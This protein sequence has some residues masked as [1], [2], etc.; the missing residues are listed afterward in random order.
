MNP[1]QKNGLYIHVPFCRTKCPYCG[2]YSI[3]STSLIPRWLE[4]LRKEVAYYK[5]RFE[6]FDTL[7]LGGGTPTLLSTRDLEK[8]MQHLLTHF[9]FAPNTEFTIEANP[10]DLTPEKVDGLKVMG[11]NRV[12]LGVQSFNAEELLFLGRRHTGAEAESALKTLR[13]SKFD[14]VGIDLIYGLEGQS[15]KGWI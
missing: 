8:I 7:Y 15:L 12:N 10:G 14:N 13:A 2:F 6:C 9:D 1:Y 3:A 5:D 11:F 4:A